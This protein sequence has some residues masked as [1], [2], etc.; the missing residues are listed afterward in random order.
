MC[1]V[2]LRKRRNGVYKGKEEGIRTCV[3]EGGAVGGA[4][5]LMLGVCVCVVM[6]LLLSSRDHTLPP[7]PYS[8]MMV[9][10]GTM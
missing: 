9:T 6:Q 3:C 10:T 1:G 7:P 8:L 5:V 2:C 4:R